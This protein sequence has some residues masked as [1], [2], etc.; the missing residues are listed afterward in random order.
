KIPKESL[1]S[2]RTTPA[3]IA[4]PEPLRETSTWYLHCNHI[5]VLFVHRCSSCFFFP[6]FLLKTD[7]PDI[8]EEARSRFTSR[9]FLEDVKCKNTSN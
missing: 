4:K 7:G 3:P 2:P 9:H 8:H 1:K 5:I 6:C